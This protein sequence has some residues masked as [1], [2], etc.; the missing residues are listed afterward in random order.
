MNH[1][2]LVITLF[3]S[4]QEYVPLFELK[5]DFNIMYR[6]NLENLYL[7]DDFTI[8]KFSPEGHLMF[9]Y[10]DNYL[11]KISSVSLGVGLKVL[12]YYQNNA[13]LVVLDNSLSQLSP[14]V[15]LN[16]Y[17]L[18]T[19]SLVCSSVQNNYWF[20]DPLQGALIKTTNTFSEIY[21]SGNLDQLLN[22]D[23][24]ANFILEWGNNLYLNDPKQGILVFDFFGTYIKTIPLLGL[25]NF[26]VTEYGIYYTDDDAL[27]YYDFKSFLTEEVKLPKEFK[28]N[29]LISNKMLYLQSDSGITAFK[30]NTF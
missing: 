3:L 30:R 6:D 8:K 16:Y 25:L 17:N 15:A 12:V 9:T 22:A 29:V 11:G 19:T 1:I 13:Q 4:V 18:G 27:M 5:E 21:N 23:I 28:G 7:V 26:Q 20:F 10:S 14:S 24:D 2:L